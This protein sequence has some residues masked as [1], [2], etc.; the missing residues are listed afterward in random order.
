MARKGI[1]LILLFLFVVSTNSKFLHVY[2]SEDT[3]KPQLI[4]RKVEEDVEPVLRS[5]RDLPPSNDNKHQ[6]FSQVNEAW[7]ANQTASTL[8]GICHICKQRNRL[9]DVNIPYAVLA[10]KN[11]FLL[12]S[13]YLRNFFVGLSTFYRN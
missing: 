13:I 10:K 7:G 9:T 5:K 6:I 11:Y 1:F 8:V 12:F 3:I 2:N 4:Q